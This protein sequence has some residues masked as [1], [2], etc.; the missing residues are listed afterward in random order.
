MICFIV[1]NRLLRHDMVAEL[2]ASATRF[3]KAGGA[4]AP[5]LKGP[6]SGRANLAGNDDDM[7]LYVYGNVEISNVITSKAGAGIHYEVGSRACTSNTAAN[8]VC[9]ETIPAKAACVTCQCICKMLLS[10]FS[11]EY[12]QRCH[13]QLHTKAALH[14]RQCCHAAKSSWIC[15]TVIIVCVVQLV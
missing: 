6:T 5:L 10:L 9:G 2:T 15:N 8:C 11:K 7:C 13:I 12:C 14:V 1:D 3:Q 4:S